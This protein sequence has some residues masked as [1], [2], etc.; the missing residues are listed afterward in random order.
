[1]SARTDRVLVLN[2]GSSSLKFGLYPAGN[3]SVAV[4]RG[5]VAGIGRQPA[6]RLTRASDDDAGEQVIR[7][8]EA[9]HSA[10]LA[11]LLPWLRARLDGELVGAG[12]RVVHG[13]TRFAEP[14]RIDD[15]ILAALREFE[16]LA[17]GHQP[18]NLAPIEAI[19]REHPDLPQVA[20]FDTAF[21]RSQPEVAQRFALPSAY[22]EAG[23]QRFGFH[24]LS[25]ESIANQLPKHL[26]ARA[27]GRVVVA[28]LGAGASMAALHKGSSV[29]TTMG[30]TAL[31]GLPM[32]KRCGALDPGVI[33]YLSQ[34][35]GMAMDDIADTLHNRSGLLG[36]SGESDDVA[37][38]LQST[39][40]GAREAL[41]LFTYSAARAVGSLAAALE[42][43]D[44]LVFTAGIGENAPAI[45]RAIVERLG[46]LGATLDPSANDTNG[47]RIDAAGSQIPILVLHTD[48][49]GMIADATRRLT[50]AD[51]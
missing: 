44:A 3:P 16:P 22:H 18:H 43:L 33:L 35:K 36:V 48:E 23:I 37:A 5:E 41:E 49:E 25:Y 2:A 42:G 4:L 7:G 15:T 8:D 20:C 26:G 9:D 6:L 30:F 17:P 21:H 38:L 47:T 34:Q 12:H 45:R 51:S 31:D 11:R 40:Q 1:M 13:G 19:R 32:A 10:V 24:G 46:W 29:A 50:S 14:V 27:D 28:H 39:S